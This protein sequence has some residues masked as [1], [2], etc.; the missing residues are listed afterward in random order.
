[1]GILDHPRTLNSGKIGVP[2]NIGREGFS[3]IGVV[4]CPSCTQ[5]AGHESEIPRV[6]FWSVIR[7]NVTPAL[8]VEEHRRV[9]DGRDPR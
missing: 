9:E 1:M 8:T 6:Q 4:P 3:A 7:C 2:L 5:R